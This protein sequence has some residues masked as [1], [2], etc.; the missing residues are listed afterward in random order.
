MRILPLLVAIG[1]ALP[2]MADEIRLQDNAPQRHVVVKGDT[3]WDI[4]EK[5]L[6]DP[7]KWPEVWQLNR[8][9]I[10]NPHLIYPGDVVVL[11][12][13]DGKPRLFLEKAAFTETVKLSPQVKSE[14]IIIK[15]QGIPSIP[16]GAIQSLMVKGAVGDAGELA[17]APRI[18]GSSDARV[19]FAKGDRVYAT[20]A[21]THGKAWRVMR[22]GQALRDP[23]NKD[24][25]SNILAYELVY[26]G[27]A[28]TE[29]PGDPQ[30]IRITSTDQEVLERDRLMPAWDG[31]PPQYVPHAPDKPVEVKVVAALGGPIHAGTWM[32][33]VL[34]R[35][36]NGGLEEGHVLA[37]YRAGRSVADPKCIRAKK[38]AFMAGGGRGHAEDCVANQDDGSVLP[39]TRVGLAFVYRVFDKLSYALVLKGTE[40]VSAGDVA[41]NP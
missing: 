41:R 39:E 1:L 3:L 24:E 14:P 26:L 21:E 40:P 10:R 4:S 17:N 38:I 29:T 13:V 31:N 37:L 30:L 11:G 20:K 33:L 18:L 8:E 27:D 16:I 35:G 2:A 34:N 32:N 25:K 36:K 15:E 7:W 23:D 6:K 22:L 28:V 12:I 9:E 5:F 19:M